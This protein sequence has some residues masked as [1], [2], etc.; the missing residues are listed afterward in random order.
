MTHANF[1]RAVIRGLEIVVALLVCWQIDFLPAQTLTLNPAVA[2]F[3]TNTPSASSLVTEFEKTS[4]KDQC[5]CESNF[6]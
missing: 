2:I 4:E 3:E 5:F 6:E 1:L